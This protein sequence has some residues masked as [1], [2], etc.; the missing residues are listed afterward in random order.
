MLDVL[1]VAVGAHFEFID[2][3]FVGNDDSMGVHLQRAEGAHVRDTAFDSLLQSA[4]LAVTI[5]DN[6]HLAG[7]HH[8]ADAHG[9]RSLGHLVQVAVKKTAVGDDGV[10]GEGL[11]PRARGE[12]RTRLVERNVS[13]GAHATHEQ[14]DA[15]SC[16]DAS[17]IIGALLN[18]VGRVAI[19]DIDVLRLDI[20]VGEEVVPHE[21]VVTLGVFLRQVAILVHIE[22]DD[23]LERDLAGL[24]H[25][26]EF[27]VHTQRGAARGAS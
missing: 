15:P 18:Q 24:V 1:E 19:E 8:S 21:R 16:L 5:D 7:I 27:T 25:C 20:N 13:I 9:E 17:L 3:H 6:H 14:I 11:L 12:R 22:G 2:S 4:C 26:D 23:I 10:L